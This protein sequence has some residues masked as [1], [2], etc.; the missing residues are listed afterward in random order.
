MVVTLAESKP[1]LSILELRKAKKRRKRNHPSY[2][3]RP[4][5]SQVMGF[6]HI[7]KIFSTAKETRN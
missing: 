7:K 2:M 1:K 6:Q 4:M 3:I 5:N